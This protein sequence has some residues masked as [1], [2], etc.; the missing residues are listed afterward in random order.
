MALYGL[1]GEKLGHS[2]STK[3]HNALGNKDFEMKE[4]T[5]DELDKYLAKPPFR[6]VNVTIPYK[7][8][9]LDYCT[10]DAISREIGAVNTLVN[11]DGKLYGY[12]TDCLGLEYLITQM[13]LDLEEKKVVILGT[14]GTSKTAKYV[15]HKLG[16]GEIV[17]ISRH[18]ESKKGTVG[19][20]EDFFYKDA[21][22]LINT[23]PVGM[24]PNV[25]ECPI[26]LEKFEKLEAVID[27]IYNP[28]TT[29]LV[30]MARKRKIKAENGL[31]MLAA[32]GWF[33]EE[34]FMGRSIENY[35]RK[36]AEEEIKK[37]IEVLTK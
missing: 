19:Y 32:Q 20:D 21:D 16:A 25:D 30:S 31:S 14:G 23:T 18:P 35:D 27:V 24:F 6:G 7:E 28:A 2:F 9:V 29:K 33:A 13:K 8:I 36:R 5:R 4:L 1:I 26:E 3:L 12:N 34:L 17:K 37:A 11:K 10:P 15:C 22:I